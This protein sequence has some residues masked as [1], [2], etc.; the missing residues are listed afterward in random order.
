MH[1]SA[2]FKEEGQ[3]S[4]RRSII[5]ISFLLY[6]DY[7]PKSSKSPASLCVVANLVM[8]ARFRGQGGSLVPSKWQNLRGDGRYANLL[9]SQQQK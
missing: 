8:P 4:R 2:R 1:V 9:Y 7:R 3:A 5:I 6:F